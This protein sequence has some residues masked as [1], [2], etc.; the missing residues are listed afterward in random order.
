MSRWSDVPS[1]VRM[2]MLP[3]IR[4]LGKWFRRTVVLIGCVG[5][6]MIL[7]AFTRLPY[8]AHHWL[9]TANGTCT[10]AP[11]AIVVLGGSGMPSG[12]E[13]LRLELAARI[14]AKFPQAV[15]HVL[16]VDDTASLRLMRAELILRGIQANRIE[17]QGHGTSTRAQAMLYREG[18]PDLVQRRIAIVTAPENMYR[19]VG[20]FRKVGFDSVCGAAAFERALFVDLDYSIEE[21]GGTW[22]APDVSGSTDLRYTFWNYLKLEITCFREYLAIAYYK[23]NGWI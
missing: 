8:D 19:S 12:P 11:A 22:M 4:F 6:L 20:T 2:L 17:V 18:H 5:F 16:H 1:T 13:L 15:V 21:L 3:L 10:V 9:G 7:I 23:L 14:G